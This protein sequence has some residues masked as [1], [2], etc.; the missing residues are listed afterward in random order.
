MQKKIRT[1]WSVRWISSAIQVPKPQ[2]NLQLHLSSL[3]R[4]APIELQIVDALLSIAAEIHRL[5]DR[6]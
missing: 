1:I 4:F 6:S 5:P 2:D 3:V